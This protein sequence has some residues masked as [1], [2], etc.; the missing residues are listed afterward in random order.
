[1]ATPREGGVYASM[2]FPPYKYHEYPKR[3]FDCRG[4]R[5]SVADQAAELR[6]KAEIPEARPQT[7]VERERDAIVSERDA[8]ANQVLKMQEDMAAMRAKMAPPAAPVP[9]ALVAPK[10][11]AKK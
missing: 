2:K 10:A 6:V 1:M 3:V 4:Q 9:P 5:V 8:L 7:E 11:E